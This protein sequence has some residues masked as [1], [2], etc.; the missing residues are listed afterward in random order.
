MTG[1]AIGPDGAVWFAMTRIGKLGRLRD[2]E[3]A[4]FGLPRDGARPIGLVVDPTGRVWYADIRGWIG[5]IPSGI[6]GR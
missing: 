3:I 1:L 6:A 4:E 2:G 5:A